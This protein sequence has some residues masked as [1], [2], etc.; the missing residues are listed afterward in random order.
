[1]HVIVEQPP[2]EC[3]A[4]AVLADLKLGQVAHVDVHTALHLIQS[5]PGPVAA[6]GGEEGQV[7]LVGVLD[8]L[9]HVLLG[10][11]HDD[12]AV[13]WAVDFDPSV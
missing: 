5:L 1:V 12:D 4:L 10:G 3:R 11:G 6:R 9:G 7:V 13:C 2:S 8:A